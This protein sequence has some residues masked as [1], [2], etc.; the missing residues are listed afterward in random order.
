MGPYMTDNS[1]IFRRGVFSNPAI[2]LI[3]VPG[4]LPP[5][6]TKTLAALNVCGFS[7]GYT[8][9]NAGALSLVPGHIDRVLV[10]VHNSTSIVGFRI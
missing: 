2:I 5:N 8:F 1:K 6:R 4:V 3:G 7:G 10:S 9:F